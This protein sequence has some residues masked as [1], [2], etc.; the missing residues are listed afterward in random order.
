MY[1]FPEELYR[2]TYPAPGSPE[3]ARRA[4]A[5]LDGRA[6]LD[7]AWGIDHGVWSILHWMYPAADIP[8]VEMSIDAKASMQELFELGRRLRPLR[9]EGVLIL[10][11]GNVVHNLGLVNWSMTGGFPWADEFDGWVRTRVLSGRYDEV[12][13]WQDA[14][15]SARRAFRTSE[16]FAPLACVLGAAEDGDR[17]EARC[18]ARTLGALSMTGYLFRPQGVK[19]E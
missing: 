6:A 8:V 12:L 10:G 2:V 4:A 17:A 3:L 15:E 7:A 9:E 1:G 18:E 11:S 5:L 16:H 14:G 13:R 19:P